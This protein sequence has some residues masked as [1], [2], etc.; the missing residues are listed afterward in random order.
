VVLLFAS[1]SCKR[2]SGTSSETKAA[3]ASLGTPSGTATTA[4]I[5]P[6]GGALN[7]SDGRVTITVPPGTLA[8]DTPFSIQA[9]SNTEPNSIGPM[10]Q[11]SPEGLRF[12]QPVTLTWH[13][14]DGDL[15]G[16][17]IKAVS[18]ATKDAEGNWVPQPGVERDAAAKTVSVAALHLS[19]WQAMLPNIRIAPNEATVR[20]RNTLELK[21]CYEPVEEELSAP[22]LA[23]SPQS[24]AADTGSNADLLAGP[25]PCDWKVN[26]KVGGDSVSGTINPN[27]TRATYT[28]PAKVPPANPVAASCEKAVT[29][30]GHQA[31][32][33]AVAY[34]R[35][36]DQKGWKGTLEY[37]YSDSSVTNSGGA[38]MTNEATRQVTGTFELEAD[39]QGW[40]MV[41]GKGTGGL[42]QKETGK[43]VNRICHTDST[44]T[45]SGDLTLDAQGSAGSGAG[46]LSITAH[47]E[48]LSGKRQNSE[49]CS[50]NGAGS[51]GGDQWNTGSF[52]VTCN[53][54]GIDYEKGGTYESP[55]PVD[56]GHGTCKLTIS[57]R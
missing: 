51:S 16:H 4:T 2:S 31:K 13:L 33:M 36:T 44:S 56:Q 27:G 20:V 47:G 15:D 18:I 34:I 22:C 26:G 53:F 50:R 43:M 35:V 24:Q 46:A 10:Y 1:L 52:G 55:V 57:P 8:A 5:G 30:Q 3:S 42:Q 28:A 23:P 12:A 38:T 29:I 40:G 17:S 54:V 14:S 21:V 48:N 37:N 41:G 9:F 25:S 11:L 39:P 19:P 6:F 32:M 7:S 45:L 49:N